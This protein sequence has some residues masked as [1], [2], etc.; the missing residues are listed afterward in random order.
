MLFYALYGTVVCVNKNKTY[1]SGTMQ[2]DSEIAIVGAGEW[3]VD[4]DGYVDVA[5]AYTLRTNPGVF[6]LSTALHLSKRGKP[7]ENFL[8]ASLS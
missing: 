7:D 5:A 3:A 1:K 8:R 4:V 6:G 2:T